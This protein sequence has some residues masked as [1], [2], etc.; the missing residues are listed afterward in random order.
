MIF[1]HVGPVPDEEALCRYAEISGHTQP[2]RL[3]GKCL[4]CDQCVAEAG[5]DP[6]FGKHYPKKCKVCGRAYVANG[7]QQL[8]CT[9]CTKR[10]YN[11]ARRNRRR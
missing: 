6:H 3:V 10:G 7:F 2:L 5:S 8:Y 1:T 11:N 4:V 9:R